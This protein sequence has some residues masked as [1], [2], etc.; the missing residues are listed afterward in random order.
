MLTCQE[1]RHGL[2]FVT[3]SRALHHP[4]LE[5]G[6]VAR[7]DLEGQMPELKRVRLRV[8]SI[9]PLEPLPAG[10]AEM[11]SQLRWVTRRG[12]PFPVSLVLGP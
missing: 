10:S 1:D 11:V 2:V 5:G 9:D 12:P 8:L 7:E 4:L 3:A 6:Q